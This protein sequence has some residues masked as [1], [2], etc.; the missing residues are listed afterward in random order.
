LVYSHFQKLSVARAAVRWK[1]ARRL[2]ASRR[3]LAQTRPGTL[4][5]RARLATRRA[6]TCPGAMAMVDG[7]VFLFLSLYRFLFVL[8]C[9][10]LFYLLV[11]QF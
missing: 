1:S 11:S 5:R 7:L 3:S 9:F 8:Y 2:A 6:T 10:V 4:A